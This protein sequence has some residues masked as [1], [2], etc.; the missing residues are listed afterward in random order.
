MSHRL[1]VKLLL[2]AALCVLVN[3]AAVWQ[4]WPRTPWYLRVR[5]GMSRDE[6]HAV[7]GR[8]IVVGNTSDCYPVEPGVVDGEHYVRVEYARDKVVSWQVYPR[9]QPRPS[10][11]QRIKKALGR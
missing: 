2:G 11:L 3:V 7:Y 9:E 10:L 8:P 6:V 4:T 1:L 5:E